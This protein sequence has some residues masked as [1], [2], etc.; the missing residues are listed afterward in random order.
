MKS[1][2]SASNIGPAPKKSLQGV[3]AILELTRGS[4][5]SFH[6]LLLLARAGPG[7]AISIGQLAKAV[8]ASPTYM[9][10]LLKKLARAGL[11]VPQR[12]RGG[13]YTLGPPAESIS[14]WQVVSALNGSASQVP[15]LPMCSECALAPQCPLKSTLQCAAADFRQRLES[16]SVGALAQLL[17]QAT[18]A[19]SS[20]SAS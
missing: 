12:G 20:G 8:Q 17:E 13:G 7:E 10:K 19:G 14:L 9:A 18:P 15:A 11:V 6:S 1:G 5:F 4:N 2:C 16:V 3:S